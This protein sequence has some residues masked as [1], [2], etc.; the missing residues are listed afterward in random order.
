MRPGRGRP[1]IVAVELAHTSFLMYAAVYVATLAHC[2]L[3]I[4]KRIA[5]LDRFD[6]RQLKEYS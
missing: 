1:K 4:Y 3:R 6:E 2:L 5:F